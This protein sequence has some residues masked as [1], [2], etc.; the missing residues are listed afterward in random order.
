MV[1]IKYVYV[2]QIDLEQDDEQYD[3]EEKRNLEMEL[4]FVKLE[5]V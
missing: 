1:E 2:E 3:G 5:E 4:R